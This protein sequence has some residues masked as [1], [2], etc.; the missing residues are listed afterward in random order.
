MTS[1]YV[2]A[3]AAAFG[4]AA[5]TIFIRQGLRGSNPYAGF[6][7]NV[8]VGT[9]GLW[10]AVV[11]TGGLHAI[12]ASGIMFFLLAGLIGTVAGR[13]LRFVAIERVGASIGAAVVNLNPL[14]STLVAILFLGETV[15]PGIVAGTGVIVLG[16]TLLSI[17][18]GP[19][20]FRP[21][22]LIFPVLS[23]VCF[24]VV[25]VLRKLGLSH[26]GA[27]QGSA[28]NATTA[29]IAY[30]TLL[31]ATGNR[32]AMRCRGRSLL[33]FVAAGIA[34]NGAV[35]MNV[36][37]L[38]LGA[39]SIVAPLYGAA[40]IFVL[41]LSLLFLRGVEALTPRMVAGTVL[42]VLGVALI[43]ALSRR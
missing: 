29:L 27:V 16:T 2:L 13:L 5:S 17:S 32:S 26:T 4:S 11:F 8:V 22:E 6:W 39:V 12:S 24:G 10:T 7:I 1:V 31:L 9:I 23:A 14:V 43:T 33:C 20:G 35:F 40:P 18:A 19:V 15:T 30:A 42:T 25:A 34:E 28:I 36:V 38:G 3:L 41:L 21:W 37:A